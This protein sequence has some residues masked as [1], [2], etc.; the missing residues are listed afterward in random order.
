MSRA[1]AVAAALLALAP[2]TA[3]AQGADS[4]SHLTVSFGRSYS[5]ARALHRPGTFVVEKQRGAALYTVIDA[6]ALISGSLSHRTWM[7]FGL[8]ARGGSSR[9]RSRRAYGSVA[10]VWAELDPILVAAAGEYEAD[11]GFDMQKGTATLEVTP[12]G[13]L[14]GLGTWVRPAFKLRWRPW[15]GVGYGNV[16]DTEAGDVEPR[17]FWRAYLRVGADYTAGGFTVA[18][19]GTSWVLNGELKGANFLTGEVSH[20]LTRALS[21]SATAEA[22]R[23]PPRFEKSSRAG[24]GLGVRF[25][26]R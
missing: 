3:V 14:P 19:E 24:L 26:T 12:L 5:S 7:E 9:P 20:A 18:L 17:N 8:R 1:A 23:E 11:G 16:F 6:G 13:G 25:A 22:G 10:R 2:C 21:L 15:L 4:A